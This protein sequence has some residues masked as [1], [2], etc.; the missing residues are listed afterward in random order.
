MK[1]EEMIVLCGANSYEQKYYFN[2]TFL[3]LP[4]EVQDELKIICITFTEEAGGILTLEFDELGNLLFKVRVD[5]K[6]Y[7]FDD[8]EAGIQIS[9]V[10]KEREETLKGI[11]LY[12]KTVFL[13][14]TIDE[15]E[16]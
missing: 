4:K 6:D 8:I 3:S 13:G 16:F 15:I 7:L 11:E 12:Y 9:R 10:Q 1:D 5:D 14:Q 2:E